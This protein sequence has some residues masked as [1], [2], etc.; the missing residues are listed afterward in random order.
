MAGMRPID[1]FFSG[2]ARLE[3]SLRPGE[4]A[5]AER[6]ARDFSSLVGPV[7][8]AAPAEQLFFRAWE[9]RE[10]RGGSL[11]DLGALAA[12]FLGDFDDASMSLGDEDWEDIRE[13]L[14]EVSE[15]MNM[16]TLTALMGEL[17]GRGKV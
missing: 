9:R 13:T 11:S 4:T 15:E 12:F 10:K 7:I 17:L 2:L 5:P 16:E 1:H 8:G 6:L 14:E 3:S